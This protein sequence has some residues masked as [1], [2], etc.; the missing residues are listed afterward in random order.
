MGKTALLIIDVQHGVF[1]RKHYD[2]KAVYQEEAF[3]ENLKTL[4]EKARAS[5]VPVIYIQHLYENFPP[6]AKGSPYWLTHPAIAPG[7]GDIV[8]EKSHADA[9]WDT[10]LLETLQN[11][12]I[13]TLVLTGMQTEFCVDTT[14]RRALSLGFTNIIVSDGHSTLDSDTLTADKII[15]HH[16]EV[17]ATQFAK[18]LPADKIMF[19]QNTKP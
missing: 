2:G 8:I 16:N 4:S 10:P 3:L 18:V 12:R 15:A 14:L 17:W 7:E 19:S 6:M 5:G 13:D 1:L 11:L 9:F